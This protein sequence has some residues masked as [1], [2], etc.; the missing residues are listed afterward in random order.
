MQGDVGHLDGGSES[1]RAAERPVT[2][3]RTAH[4]ISPRPPIRRPPPRD[5]VADPD[6]FGQV[7]TS[8]VPYQHTA[9]RP[10]WQLRERSTRL[11]G[12]SAT[13]AAGEPP[14]TWPAVPASAGEP[15]PTTH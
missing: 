4:E 8:A 12:S 10:T 2:Q 11:R 9:T 1:H 15:C 6:L 13:A 3:S 7:A 14:R 5:Y